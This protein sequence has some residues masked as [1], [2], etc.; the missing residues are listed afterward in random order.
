MSL[1]VENR[2]SPWGRVQDWTQHGDGIEFV[3]TAGH[4]GFHL[5]RTRMQTFRKLFPRFDT[6]AGGPWFEED[7]DAA[8]VIVAFPDRFSREEVWTAFESIKHMARHGYDRFTDAWESLQGFYGDETFAAVRRIATEE[9]ESHTGKWERGGL[10]GGHGI[11]GWEVQMRRVGTTDRCTVR[12][13]E[14]PTERFY[15]D[16]QLSAFERL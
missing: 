4:G 6:Y 14:Y 11:K 9:Q 1:C 5:D 12:M 7:C 10:C 3:S 15:S 13:D 2:V 8:L 16:E